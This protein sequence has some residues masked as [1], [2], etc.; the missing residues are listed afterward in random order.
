[1]SVIEPSQ[2]V[3]SHSIIRRWVMVLTLDGSIGYGTRDLNRTHSK[4]FD[5]TVYASI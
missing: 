5:S 4:T 2:N 3:T 1:M